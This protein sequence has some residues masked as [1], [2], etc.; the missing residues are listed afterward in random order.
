[1]ALAHYTPSLDTSLDA[2]T[3]HSSH[4]ATLTA[5][6]HILN[7]PVKTLLAWEHL[8]SRILTSLPH[9][10]S[11]FDEAAFATRS[12]LSASPAGFTSSLPSSNLLRSNEA[13]SID[14]FFRAASLVASIF[15][16]NGPSAVTLLPAFLEDCDVALFLRRRGHY[17]LQTDT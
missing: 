6:L 4:C 2:L 8:H 14:L 5:V 10:F 11:C 13:L 7:P 12:I 1:M 3:H 15:S 17:R 16:T 9:S